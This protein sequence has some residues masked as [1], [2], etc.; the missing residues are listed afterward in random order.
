MYG[1]AFLSLKLFNTGN[2]ETSTRT[3]SVLGTDVG[4]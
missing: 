4:S 2:T 1:K 3:E